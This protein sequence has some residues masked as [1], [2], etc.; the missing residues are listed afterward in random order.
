[1]N[2][3]IWG[4]QT[5]DSVFGVQQRSSGRVFKVNGYPLDN[6]NDTTSLRAALKRQDR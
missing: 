4:L 1:M 6:E 5:L 2:N 3:N